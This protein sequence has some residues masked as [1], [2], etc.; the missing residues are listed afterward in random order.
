MKHRN[1]LVVFILPFVTL[2]IYQLYWLVK[3][4]G[5][6]NKRGEKIP[7]AWILLI[8]FI[9]PIWFYWVY[10]KGVDHVTNHRMNNV[11]A[12]ILVWLLGGIG[13]AII[14]D[15]F[16]DISG[17]PQQN[18]SARPQDLSSSVAPVI[19][20]SVPTQPVEIPSQNQSP[21]PPAPPSRQPPLVSG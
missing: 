17:A 18:W 1:P 8:P 13:S 14:Q 21:K 7:T 3:T 15:S 16:N 20:A 4:K 19:P 11:V 9:G 6:M 5:E 12:F 2:G 10:S